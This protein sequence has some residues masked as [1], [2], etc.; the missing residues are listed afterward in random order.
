MKKTYFYEIFVEGY[1]PETYANWFEGMSVR[2][3]NESKTTSIGNLADQASLIGVLNKIQS[4]NLEVISVKRNDAEE[5]K[6][7]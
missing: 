4:L 5:K 6:L 3:N 2:F 7:D 1:I